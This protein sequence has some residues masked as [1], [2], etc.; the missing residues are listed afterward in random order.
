[1]SWLGGIVSGIGHA[2]GSAAGVISHIPIL[3]ATPI[4]TVA[5]LVNT[6]THFGGGSSAMP[7][8]ATFPGITPSA[9]PPTSTYTGSSSSGS[10]VMTAS[11]PRIPRPLKHP[12][13]SVAGGRTT[14]TRK[15]PHMRVM[16]ERA[17]RRAIHR[18]R[19]ARK[20]LHAIE[21]HLPKVK[22]RAGARRR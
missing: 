3:N 10:T 15:R 22:E 5:G 12:T 18:I 14:T 2:I 8:G 9:F 4:G 21:R 6:V 17:A 13:R 16:N 19:G 1:M 20:L 11:G 7:G